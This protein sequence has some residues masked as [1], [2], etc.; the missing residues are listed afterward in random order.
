MA[1]KIT[2]DNLIGIGAYMIMQQIITNSYRQRY[3]FEVTQV[4]K[5]KLE[6]SHAWFITTLPEQCNKS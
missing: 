5:N 6:D 1:T 4:I 3:E 2:S